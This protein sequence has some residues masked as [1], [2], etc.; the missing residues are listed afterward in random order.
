MYSRRLPYWNRL[1]RHEKSTKHQLERPCHAW[2]DSWDTN[3]S[4]FE[5]Q[6]KASLVCWSFGQVAETRDPRAEAD[7]IGIRDRWIMNPLITRLLRLFAARPA[8]WP[9]II[10]LL[11]KKKSQWPNEYTIKKCRVSD[12][13][14]YWSGNYWHKLKDIILPFPF[15][16][17]FTHTHWAN[18]S[19]P[20]KREKPWGRG[21]ANPTYSSGENWNV[22]TAWPTSVTRSPDWWSLPLG[23]WGFSRFCFS[24]E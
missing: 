10:K 4:I 22:T 16:P 20:Q 1:R 9:Y 3:T 15:Q 12:I 24:F 11:E 18:P 6:A 7:P 21:W 8:C 13:L 2:E 17:F 14:H 23:M 19:F 5:T